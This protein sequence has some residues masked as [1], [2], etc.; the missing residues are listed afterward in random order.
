MKKSSIFFL[1]LAGIFLGILIF[2][3]GMIVGNRLPRTNDTLKT[4]EKSAAINPTA[5]AK[6]EPPNP[7]S[8]AA[9]KAI[10]KNSEAK[11]NPS[12]KPIAKKPKPKKPIA[13]KPPKEKVKDPLDHPSSADVKKAPPIVADAKPEKP[14]KKGSKAKVDQK[15]KPPLTYSIGI[16]AFLDRV[17]A[18][19]LVDDLK[20]N[21]HKAYIVNAWDSRGQLW[22]TVRIGHFAD[23]DQASKIALELK[24]KER[25]MTHIQGMGALGFV[26]NTQIFEPQII[27][28]ASTK[29]E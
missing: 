17:E 20:A 10:Q 14:A 2:I 29:A 8:I 11:E 9:N 7:E 15:A 4:T 26:D 24:Q 21:N 25:L 1:T 16:G 27:K 6:V 12:P 22:S 28:T 13:T 18:E 19:K 3:A 5:N 23:I